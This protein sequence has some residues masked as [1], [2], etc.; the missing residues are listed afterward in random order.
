MPIVSPIKVAEIWLVEANYL[1]GTVVQIW[2][3]MAILLCGSLL[4]ALSV[5]PMILM[6]L[7]TGYSTMLATC[8]FTLAPA[9]VACCY[10]TGRT[11]IYSKSTLG[12]FLAALVHY[13]WRSCVLAIPI[14]I[15][16]VMLRISFPFL[17]SV[18]TLI[19]TVGIV[20]Q[21]LALFIAFCVFIFAAPI[22]G[23]FQVNVFHAMAYGLVLMLRS[24][25]MAIGLVSMA[26]LLGMLANVLGAGMW[27]IIPLIF[28]PFEVNT[29]LMLV[30]KTIE[31]ER[32][33]GLSK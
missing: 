14:V 5:L 20:F 12:D 24:P 25:L 15:L 22:L 1:R 16:V 4:V 2:E 27:L 3:H 23:L 19:F 9:W 13:Y 21:I 29:T 8:L 31:L 28:I 7:L 26:F 6:V 30:R 18:P 11:T 17:N 33:S 32:S 10:M